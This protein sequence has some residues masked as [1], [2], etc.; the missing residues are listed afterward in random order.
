MTYLHPTPMFRR[1]LRMQ[2]CP[3][4]GASAG[5]G[6]SYRSSVCGYAGL[7]LLL[8]AH[9]GRAVRRKRSGSARG[10]AASAQSCRATAA[11][12]AVPSCNH[13]AASLLEQAH[14]N[15]TGPFVITCGKRAWSFRSSCCET[16]TALASL[17]PS[18]L[19]LL[20][21]ATTTSG[22]IYHCA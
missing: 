13:C 22:G 11:A 9:D 21:A 18:T 5:K 10:A 20:V 3:S 6:S 7:L 19:M 16:T 14:V 8:R 1:L 4:C 2:D 12:R 17:R 15:C